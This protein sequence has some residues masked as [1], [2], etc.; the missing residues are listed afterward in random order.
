M[1]RNSE[2]LQIE[3]P[4]LLSSAVILHSADIGNVK[5][6]PDANYI[7][8]AA[9]STDAR[10]Y[11]NRPDV[12]KNNIQAATYNFCRLIANGSTSRA[13]IL[14]VSS[15]AVYGYQSPSIKFLT[16]DLR[17]SSFGNL[18]DGKRDYAFAKKDAENEVL[19]LRN[20]NIDI[21][22]ARCFAFVGPWLPRTQ[23]FAIGNFIQ[24]GLL[25]KNINIKANFPVI[26]SYMHSDD[27]VVWLM[28]ICDSA[29]PS[30]PIFNVGS[31]EEV[32][33]NQI[34]EIIAKEFNVNVCRSQEAQ[35]GKIDR[36]IP[37][38]KRAKSLLGLRISIGLVDAIQRTILAI[39]ND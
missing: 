8:H 18:A 13:K 5:E 38:I 7:I 27:L 31:D 34:A 3:A 4:N 26:R 35:S 9:A 37:S 10:A 17:V 14:Y 2:K 32:T 1:S 23:H 15:G 21:S 16:E 24:D 25:G 33:I 28:T 12:E 30:C 11:L 36:Y 22:I 6:L 39:K 29:N 20:K 19:R